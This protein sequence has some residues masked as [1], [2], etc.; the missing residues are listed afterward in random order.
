M[1]EW[2]YKVTAKKVSEQ[3][4]G[5]LAID[6]GFLARSAYRRM[7]DGAPGG[8]IN[9]VA[10][11]EPG[12][13]LHV[14]YVTGR[15]PAQMGSFRVLA[16]AGDRFD[17]VWADGDAALVRVHDVEA[18]VA[19]LDLL[20]KRPPVGEGYRH[21]PKLDAFTGWLVQRLPDRAQPQFD[22]LDFP[23]RN[24]L[25]PVPVTGPAAAED[26]LL[27]RVLHDPAVMGGKPCIRGTR[28]T[29]GTI[30]GLL[31]VGQSFEAILSDFPY[32]TELDL[33]AA[34]AYAAWRAQ[35]RELPSEAA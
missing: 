11:V 24:T 32:L 16:S 5:H 30:L 28:V 22:D 8:R 21:D 25:V 3:D 34:L 6:L 35:E 7:R 13:I 4:T 23:G 9:N 10:K 29:V 14:Y 20:R 2:A 12:D 1:R 18:N 15:G 17:R 19:L 31:S 33:R 27:S 26:E